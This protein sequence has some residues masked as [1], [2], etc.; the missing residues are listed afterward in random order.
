VGVSG[1]KPV[2]NRQ[3]EPKLPESK[4]DGYRVSFADSRVNNLRGMMAYIDGSPWTV[5]FYNQILDKHNDLKT[6]DPSQLAPYQTY[7]LIHDLEI[8]VTSPLDSQIDPQTQIAT[9]TGRANIGS[10]TPVNVEDVF[11]AEASGTGKAIFRVTSVQRKTHNVNSVYEIEYVLL[12]M[13]NQYPSYYEVLKQKTTEEFYFVKDRLMDNGQPILKS[14]DFFDMR[15][16]KVDYDRIAEDYFRMFLNKNHKTLVLPGQEKSIYDNYLVEYIAA[17]VEVNQS[18]E[19]RFVR[20][21]FQGQDNVLHQP[22]FWEMMLKRDMSLLP[23]LNKKMGLISKNSGSNNSYIGSIRFHSIDYHVYP[24]DPNMAPRV[25]LSDVSPQET[26]QPNLVATSVFKNT[27]E[28]DKTAVDWNTYRHTEGD[29]ALIPYVTSDD[30]YV[31][32]SNFYNQTSTMSVLEILTKDY[33][34]G[35]SLDMRMLRAVFNSYRQW[36]VLEKF[37]YGPILLTLMK[38]AASNIYT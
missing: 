27:E 22:Q 14:S 21:L 18:H 37:Y 12:Y 31:L 6:F 10:Y 24:S 17:I 36:P 23:Y 1:H 30:F 13:V 26:T 9:V 32:S 35:L 5:D 3:P 20:R 4:P 8:R 11:V 28:G 19:S 33:L 15:Q 29:R 34:L 2:D 16:L 7:S 25:E 38:E